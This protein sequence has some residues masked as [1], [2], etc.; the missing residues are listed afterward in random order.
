MGMQIT[1]L[2]AIWQLQS[3]LAGIARMSR[4]IRTHAKRY[5]DAET[6]KTVSISKGE[7]LGED[8]LKR[9]LLIMSKIS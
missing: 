2:L 4:R 5:N 9:I 7:R 1:I 3:I 8:Q 6:V